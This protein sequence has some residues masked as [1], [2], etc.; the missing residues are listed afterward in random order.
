MSRHTARIEA[1][2]DPEASVWVAES[3][4]VPGLATE[5]ETVEALIEKLRVLVPAL[6]EANGISLPIEDH[7]LPFHVIASRHDSTHVAVL[8]QAGLDKAF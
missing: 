3:D 8:E 5:T 1:I 2:W 4:D 7:E 6:L